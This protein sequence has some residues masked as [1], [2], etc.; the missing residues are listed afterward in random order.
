MDV[1]NIAAYIVIAIAVVT[2]VYGLQKRS[3][4]HLRHDINN[5]V[6]TSCLQSIQPGSTINKFNDFVDTQIQ[7]NEESREINLNQNDLKRAHLNELN[8][9]RLIK[10]K[11]AI[12]TV[13]QCNKPIIK[14]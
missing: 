13:E 10:D 11:I 8:I 6:R 3:D 7:A 2:G 9:Q 4:E 1:K 5:V 14:P 12:P